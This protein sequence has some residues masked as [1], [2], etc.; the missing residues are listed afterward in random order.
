MSALFGIG[1]LIQKKKKKKTALNWEPLLERARSSEERQESAS[2]RNNVLEKNQKIHRFTGNLKWSWNRRGKSCDI[3]Q[4]NLYCS[5]SIP[6][7]HG[8]KWLRS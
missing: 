5:C 6:R 3:C 7:L 8:K 1:A 4:D 2:L